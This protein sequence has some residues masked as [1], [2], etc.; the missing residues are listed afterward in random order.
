M[1]LQHDMMTEII[2]TLSELKR[3]HQLN[4]ELLEQLSVC[5]SWLM[6]HNIPIPNKATIC[7]LL[8]KAKAL[9][10][11]IQTEISDEFLHGDKSDEDFTEPQTV[12]FIR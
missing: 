11:E 1:T 9:I 8:T 3:M 7:S 12:R 10:S 6:E 2:K 4:L 5:C